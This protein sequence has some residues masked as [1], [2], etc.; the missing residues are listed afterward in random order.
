M[1]TGECFILFLK[2]SAHKCHADKEIHYFTMKLLQVNVQLKFI[3]IAFA[4]RAYIFYI[5]IISKTEKNRKCL[6]SAQIKSP[7]ICGSLKKGA[8]KAQG[9]NI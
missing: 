3:K 7:Y 4:E 5:I 8:K 6:M 2:L 9:K 1:S